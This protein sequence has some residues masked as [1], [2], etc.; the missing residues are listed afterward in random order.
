MRGAQGP[1]REVAHLTQ[2]L[3]LSPDQQK[4]VRAVLEQ[5]SEQMRALRNKTS[6]GRR[7]R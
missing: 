5:Q 7:G 2:I 1:E 4:G 6:K 3:N